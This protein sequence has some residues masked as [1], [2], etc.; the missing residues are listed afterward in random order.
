MMK[1]SKDSK[2]YPIEYFIILMLDGNIKRLVC[3]FQLEH[4]Q[5]Q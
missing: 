3:S 4:W 2:K 5:N 1:I